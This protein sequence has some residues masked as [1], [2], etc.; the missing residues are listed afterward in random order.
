MA[1]I[2]AAAAQRVAAEWP[3]AVLGQG[4]GT[5]HQAGPPSTCGRP[6]SLGIDAVP[7]GLLLV[8]SLAR[9]KVSGAEAQ[10]EPYPDMLPST[11]L[12]Q[13]ASWEVPRSLQQV[14][15]GPGGAALADDTPFVSDVLLADSVEFPPA[16]PAAAAAYPGLGATGP[17]AAGPLPLAEW[18]G[19]A[20]SP[21]TDAAYQAPGG[22]E[23]A[24]GA[25]GRPARAPELAAPREPSLALASAAGTA[26]A[27]A[28]EGSAPGGPGRDREAV[29]GREAGQLAEPPEL[30]LQ[31]PG[32][33]SLAEAAEAS[34]PAEEQEL[35]GSAGE[36]PA[37]AAAGRGRPPGLAASAE[38]PAAAAPVPA[39]LF[40]QPGVAAEATAAATA[41]PAAG[42][43]LEMPADYGQEVAEWRA[44]Q[45]SGAAAEAEARALRELRRAREAAAAMERA[46]AEVR[47]SSERGLSAAEARVGAARRVQAAL[48]AEVHGRSTSG[49]TE[50]PVPAGN[51][52]ADG[53]GNRKWKPHCGGEGQ[54]RCNAVVQAITFG[55]KTR[56]LQGLLD[57]TAIIL[58]WLASLYVCCCVLQ[59]S[60]PIFCC[61]QFGCFLMIGMVAFGVMHGPPV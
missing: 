61:C 42:E 6:C 21:A 32:I 26:S 31:V 14:G 7:N 3:P 38:A 27:A 36:A 19:L 57:W 55:H 39:L 60:M 56:L 35:L 13:F 41:L 17:P 24:I 16:S 1:A 11:G 46:W 53:E 54:G 52:T 34:G 23:A 5:A 33:T 15:V 9:F 8:Q 50:D 43:L 12:S 48:L 30:F 49:G 51:D 18:E 58:G 37:A 10:T 44:A 4:P 22:A 20:S 2:A 28:A 59:V 47:A 25:A 29:E 40:A 45:A